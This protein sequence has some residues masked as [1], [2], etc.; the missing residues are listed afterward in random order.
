MKITTLTEEQEALLTEYANM[1]ETLEFCSDPIDETAARSYGER[2]MKWLRRDYLATI[3][4]DGPIAACNSLYMLN[5]LE[6]RMD[7]RVPDLVFDQT[8]SQINRHVIDPIEVQTIDQISGDVRGMIW[9]HIGSHRQRNVSLQVE[10]WLKEQCELRLWKQVKDQIWDQVKDRAWDRILEQDG[11]VFPYLSGQWMSN[12]VVL[13]RY[14]REVLQLDLPSIWQI[15]DQIHFGGVFPLSKFVV[16]FPRP[17]FIHRNSSGLLHCDNGPALRYADGFSLFC[18][19]GVLVPEW[20]VSKSATNIDP[21]E[22]AKI[23][24]AEVRREFVRKVGIER[25]AQSC[26]AV[27]LDKQD[28]YELLSIDL[29]GATGKCPYLKMLNPSTGV[30]H[31]EAIGKAIITVEAALKWRN[32]SDL[33]PEQLT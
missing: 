17:E 1:G 29:G 18:L 28:A 16:I 20:L 4:S 13:H 25:I 27:I 33:I 15:E 9:N 30:W 32:Q 22:F 11:T 23:E 2:L 8:R 14:Y 10:R 7:N 3:I 24:N 21:R 26:E 5:V 6:A 31:L 12:Y 19:N